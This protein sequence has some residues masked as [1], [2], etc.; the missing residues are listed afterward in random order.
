M[1]QNLNVYAVGDFGPRDKWNPEFVISSLDAWPLLRVLTQEPSSAQA[2]ALALALKC[3]LSVST[4]ESV[5]SPL[6][7]LGVVRED[8]DRYRLGFAWFTVADQNAECPT[9]W[10]AVCRVL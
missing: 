8:G 10:S 5:L 3:G 4:V 2:L 1:R 6:V 7:D 9:P